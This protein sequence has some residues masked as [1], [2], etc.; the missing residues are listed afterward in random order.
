VEIFMA[1]RSGKCVCLGLAVAVLLAAGAPF[2]LVV[3]DVNG[4]AAKS[5]FTGQS[6]STL[7]SNEKGFLQEYRE[8]YAR[9]R[10]FYQNITIEACEKTFARPRSRD[11]VFPPPPDADLALDWVRHYTF[12][13]NG[14]NYY[15]MDRSQHDVADLSK[16][17]NSKIGIVTPTGDYLLTKNLSTGKYFV[18]SYAINRAKDVAEMD[19]YIF[20]IAPFAFIAFPLDEFLLKDRANCTV[21]K[22][23]LQQDSGE[24][25]VVVSTSYK[26]NEEWSRMW[27]RFYRDRSWALKDIHSEAMSSNDAKYLT[28]KS[29]TCSYSGEKDGIPLLRHCSIESSV[30]VL[31]TGKTKINHRQVFEIERITPGPAAL[32]YFDVDALLGKARI[33]EQVTSSR[34]RT[35]CIL[36]GIILVLVGILLK[37]RMA[38]TRT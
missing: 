17:V 16:T 26:R 3:A 28:M 15:L 13:A 14:G 27:L 31:S 34:F 29:Q 25:L 7:S 35:I 19:G 30:K 5:D 12:R 9:L 32:S 10:T 33:G 22:V 18:S 1:F 21:D 37:R 4:A 24:N 23:E 38:S 36:L 6:F 20:Q 11:G 8:H 2:S